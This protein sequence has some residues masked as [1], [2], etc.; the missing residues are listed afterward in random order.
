MNYAQLKGERMARCDARWSPLAVPLMGVADA[1]LAAGARKRLLPGPQL[2][3]CGHE[4]LLSNTYVMAGLQERCRTC[5][6]ASMA[7]HRAKKKV[8]QVRAKQSEMK[9]VGSLGDGVDY[10]VCD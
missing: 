3:A 1:L 5:H 7:E 8:E 2:F 10:S 9:V 4:R 6:A